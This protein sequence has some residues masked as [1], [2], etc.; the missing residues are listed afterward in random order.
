[1]VKSPVQDVNSPLFSLASSARNLTAL[2]PLATMKI[3]DEASPW[4]KV[5][6]MVTSQEMVAVLVARELV[7][8]NSLLL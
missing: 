1:M 7:M 6:S 5:G 2:G 8:G 3:T 4:V